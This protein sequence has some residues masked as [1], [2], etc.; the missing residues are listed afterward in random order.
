MVESNFERQL[1]NPRRLVPA[2]D[3]PKAARFESNFARPKLGS[4]EGIEE[5]SAELS[6]DTRVDRDQLNQ[7]EAEV[8][9]S[10]LSTIQETRGIVKGEIGP[11][12]KRPRLHTLPYLSPRR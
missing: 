12:W 3:K 10:I 5:F 4:I 7:R 1:D 9:D 11:Y 6:V 8:L 2:H